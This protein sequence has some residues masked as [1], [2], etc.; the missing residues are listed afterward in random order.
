MSKRKMDES[1]A[2]VKA[3]KQAK[4]THEAWG[5]DPW[6]AEKPRERIVLDTPS[7]AYRV[8]VM[9][10]SGIDL[11]AIR[12]LFDPRFEI[13]SPRK[14][15]GDSNQYNPGV[16]MGQ[17]VVAFC[18]ESAI[19]TSIAV[20]N[21]RASLTNVNHV[22]VVGSSGGGLPT[23]DNDVRLGDVIIGE[24]IITFDSGKPVILPT[25]R[26]FN[27]MLANLTAKMM[28]LGS[29]LR[30]YMTNIANCMFDPSEWEKPKVTDPESFVDNT[31][32][33]R[34][35]ARRRIGHA[36]RI[37]RGII[38]SGYSSISS[39][40]IRAKAQAKY[41]GALAVDTTSMGSNVSE[42][43]IF[44]IRGISHLCDK[45][46]ERNRE[47]PWMRYAAT[48]AAAT[49]AAFL[50]CN[51]QL[52]SPV[53]NV[54]APLVPY[55]VGI[56]ALSKMQFDTVVAGMKCADVKFE[57]S[58]VDKTN[59][60]VFGVM[61]GARVIVMRAPEH[62]PPIAVRMFCATFPQ[63]QQLA[64]VGTGGGIPEVDIRVGD[65]SVLM[66]SVPIAAGVEGPLAPARWWSSA[67]TAMLADSKTVAVTEDR[68]TPAMDIVRPGE[69]VKED[70]PFCLKCKQPETP[71]GAAVERSTSV[72][73]HAGAMAAVDEF[74]V[75]AANRAKWAAESV[76]AIGLASDLLFEIDIGYLVVLGITH[77][78][79]SHH[80]GSQDVWEH[81]G[82]A[83]AA[84][85]LKKLLIKR[86][87]GSSSEEVVEQ[88]AVE[89]KS[90][91]AYNAYAQVQQRMSATI[92][93][94]MREN[95]ELKNALKVEVKAESK[96][97]AAKVEGK[98]A[99]KIKADAPLLAEAGED[100]YNCIVCSEHRANVAVL[101]CNHIRYCT[102]C[103]PKETF[104]CPGCRVQATGVEVMFMG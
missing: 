70:N 96:A 83:T 78:A 56:V 50:D 63:L 48:A 93:R 71:K 29:P 103:A 69:H 26:H 13:K 14:H 35:Y 22:F 20:A 4:T 62:P 18:A 59:V 95:S 27:A 41:P 101:P 38:L 44:V 81:Y 37:E 1:P 68:P 61:G 46:V 85:T 11:A 33:E 45:R 16:I 99:Y 82:T 36:P 19:D 88:R 65:V 43:E 91:A 7:T 60:Y 64:V 9:T 79:D 58:P 23:A 42:I 86:C 34:K 84:A 17:L 2:E 25:N 94:L 53:E 52:L 32:S 15:S 10:N 5:R 3:S 80:P 73:I 24:S 66:A 8:A 21:L 92:D 12:A 39:V 98:F 100:E 97:D 57:R 51:R 28:L 55:T 90:D 47:S 49:L 75:T 40:E 104:A 76:V 102:K 6:P 74:D 72:R 89:V 67:M 30:E 87:G 54:P 31:G 77:Y